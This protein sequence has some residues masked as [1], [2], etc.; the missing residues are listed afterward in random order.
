MLP[1]FVDRPAV[2]L[3]SPFPNLRRR[4]M[5]RKAA[6]SALLGDSSG[7]PHL[8]PQNLKVMQFCVISSIEFN[9]LKLVVTLCV[10]CH[11]VSSKMLHVS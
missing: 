5:L 6:E 3:M 9:I 11:S 1:R 7:V 10:G 2:V 8:L 4:K